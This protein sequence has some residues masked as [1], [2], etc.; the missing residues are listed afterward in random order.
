MPGTGGGGMG[1]GGPNTDFIIPQHNTIN[2]TNKA[3]KLDNGTK[4]SEPLPKTFPKIS[5]RVTFPKFPL[6][7]I[8]SSL[9]Q[10]VMILQFLL[11]YN[12][13]RE[14]IMKNIKGFL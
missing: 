1:E 8:F 14:Q 9:A 3:R 11:C 4:F 6:E 10:G 12:K 5:P 2:L 7:I 13:Y